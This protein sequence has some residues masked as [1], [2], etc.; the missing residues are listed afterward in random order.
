MFSEGDITWRNLYR[1]DHLSR[2]FGSSMSEGFYFVTQRAE[3]PKLA[4]VPACQ[5]KAG[6]G[7]TCPALE[8]SCFYCM[9]LI[10]EEKPREEFKPR[11]L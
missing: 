7:G 11:V 5:P 3:H 9:I 6:K 10:S 2:L 8:W 1:M 4:S